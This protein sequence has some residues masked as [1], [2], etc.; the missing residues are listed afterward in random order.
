MVSSFSKAPFHSQFNQITITLQIAKY[1]K[2]IELSSFWS[3]VTKFYQHLLSLAFAIKEI[4]ENPK[5]LPNITLGF[6]IVDCYHDVRMTYQST[7]DLLYKLHHYFPNYKC[8][9][10][11]NL[12]AVIGG[13][14]LEVSSYMADLLGLYKIPQVGSLNGF[15][16]NIYCLRELEGGRGMDEIDGITSCCIVERKGKQEFGEMPC[17]SWSASDWNA[18]GSRFIPDRPG[19]R[20]CGRFLRK[21]LKT[22]SQF[23]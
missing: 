1:C 10:Q 18:A 16:H 15:R 7:L 8:D 20:W 5:I 19:S 14:S 21:I 6:H 13:H 22:L 4:N 3:I 2:N 12:I 11:K 9:V 17:L 23:K